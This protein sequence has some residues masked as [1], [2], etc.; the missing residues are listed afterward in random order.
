MSKNIKIAFNF[1]LEL[2]LRNVVI[3]RHFHQKKMEVQTAMYKDKNNS[4]S[5]AATCACV[6][7]ELNIK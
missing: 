4:K 3:G 6:K 2:R 7:L 5:R 1:L